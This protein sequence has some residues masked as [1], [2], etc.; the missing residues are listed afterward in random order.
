[1][2]PCCC[3]TFA[4]WVE[5]QSDA[6]VVGEAVTWTSSEAGTVTTVS[7]L[8]LASHN[9]MVSAMCLGSMPVGEPQ[10]SR[11]STPVVVNRRSAVEA[12][13]EANVQ[14]TA[15]R[16]QRGQVDET[17]LGRL[18]G[19]DTALVDRSLPRGDCRPYQESRN[20]ETPTVGA[21]RNV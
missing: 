18:G 17:T 21:N 16:E 8:L 15:F 2:G 11:R 3:D 10:R 19:K 12:V 7:P 13:I 4:F 9:P 20:D 6:A 5:H 1:M 14:A